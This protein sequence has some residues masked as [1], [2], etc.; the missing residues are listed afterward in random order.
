MY[1]FVKRCQN[2]LSPYSAWGQGGLFT[3]HQPI[4]DK[5]SIWGERGRGGPR[6]FCVIV[7]LFYWVFRSLCK[8]PK[9]QHKPFWEKWPILAIFRPKSAFL[10]GRGGP[11]NFFPIGIFI[12]LLLRSP[13]KIL[14]WQHKHFWEKQPISAFVHPKSAFLGWQGG[15]PKIFFIGIF[16]FL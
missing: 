15:S 11:R 13:C 8:I 6:I 3:C 1:Y 7:L 4:R 16:I 5:A 12:V 2:K 10:G 14:K 9:L